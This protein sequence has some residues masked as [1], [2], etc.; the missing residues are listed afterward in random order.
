MPSHT[1]V[2]RRYFVRQEPLPSREVVATVLAVKPEHAAD[3]KL[4][5]DR[6]YR[7]GVGMSYMPPTTKPLEDNLRH[8]RFDLFLL[9]NQCDTHFLKTRYLSLS[10]TLDFE[11]AF[12]MHW[13]ERYEASPDSFQTLPRQEPAESARHWVEIVRYLKTVQPAARIIFLCA[14]PST[15]ERDPD[16]K[17]RADAFA[18]PFRAALDS[19]A[20]EIVPPLQVPREL[21]KLPDDQDHFDILV[22]RAL[23]GH[24][25]TSCLSPPK[26]AA[27]TRVTLADAA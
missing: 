17:A 16:R 9:D 21:T 14:S 2:T 11:L 1:S 6:M 8:E 5:V 12:P 22:C 4:V 23:A 7:R 19:I 25:F 24:V 10:G 3:A 20:I 27:P 18:G 13:S 26:A 15:V